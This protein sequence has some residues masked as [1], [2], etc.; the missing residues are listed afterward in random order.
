MSD[1]AKN[2]L[3]RGQALANNDFN[4]FADTLVSVVGKDAVDLN[5]KDAVKEDLSDT[6]TATHAV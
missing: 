3:T 5:N 1:E 4:N 2:Y 6:D